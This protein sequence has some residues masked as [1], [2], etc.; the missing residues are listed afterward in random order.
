MEEQKKKSVFH[1]LLFSRTLENKKPSHQI[2]YIA[3]LTAFATASNFWEIKFFD[4]QFSLTIVISMLVGMILGS[5]YG[6]TA[7]VLGDFLGFLMN[8]HPPYMFWIGL[9]TGLFAFIA[10]L[11]NV[12]P[13]KRK[14]TLFL[15]LLIVC[16]LTFFVCTIGVNSTGFYLYNKKMGFSTAV[17]NYLTEKWGGK[18]TF[19]GYVAYR[20]FF[21]GQI[22]NSLVNYVLLFFA[23]PLL[24]RIKPLKIDI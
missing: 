12:V 17:L 15:K 9:S 10:G 13:T 16:I 4:T 5:V 6:F 20:L 3:V 24:K 8:P 1:S 18:V 19:L 7:C 23:V 2:A 21:K 11:V 14:W 22:I